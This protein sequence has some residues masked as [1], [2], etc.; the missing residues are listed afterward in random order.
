MKLEIK[1]KTRS[2]RSFESCSGSA[3]T[4]PRMVDRSS[5]HSSIVNFFLFFIDHLT[6]IKFKV[7]YVY[8]WINYSPP[9]RVQCIE[10]SVIAINP[11]RDLNDIYLDAIFF[12]FFFSSYKIFTS[13]QEESTNDKMFSRCRF[14]F[15]EK[16]PRGRIKVVFTKSKDI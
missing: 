3:S 2:S 10:T 5:L 12:L 11:L 7:F 1:R 15:N 4:F 13:E 8:L 14:G 16:H 9:R 6:L